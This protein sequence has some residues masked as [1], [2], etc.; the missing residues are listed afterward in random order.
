MAGDHSDIAIVQA[1][2][3]MGLDWGK[4]SEA[5]ERVKR[6][7]DQL[8]MEVRKGFENNMFIFCVGNKCFGLR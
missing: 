6:F 4:N 8:K 1:S 3:S 5:K 2:N 7:G